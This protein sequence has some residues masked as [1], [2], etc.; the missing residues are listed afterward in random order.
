MTGAAP[1]K[2][3]KD[4]NRLQLWLTISAN[5]IVF[6]A[7]AQSQV[8][9]TSGLNGLVTEATNLLPV[10]LA[11]V[12]TSVANGLFTANVKARLV[13][14]RWRHAL[15]GH[16]AFSEHAASD[17][18]INFEQL[19]KSLGRNF[20]LIPIVKIAHGIASSS[21]SRTIRRCNIS[22]VSFYLRATTPV[23][24]FCS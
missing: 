9:T 1:A 19:K 18:R 20:R 4:Q 16:R 22:I 13:F 7:V 5:A 2:S 14:L 17:P 3:L 8:V 24:L 6:Y 21:R 11:F 10:G 12:F 15:P 23:S